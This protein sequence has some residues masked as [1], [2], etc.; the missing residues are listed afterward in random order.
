MSRKRRETYADKKARAN[1]LGYSTPYQQ[2]KARKLLGLSR[3]SKTPHRREFPDTKLDQ[4]L[5]TDIHK[6]GQES[7]AW[8]NAHS[9][10]A[11]TRYPSHG[12]DAQKRAFKAAFVDKPVKGKAGSRAKQQAIYAYLDKY[13]PRSDGK[14]WAQHYG[15]SH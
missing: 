14:S 1:R 9:R 4:L 12:S 11:I 5:R 3:S 10:Q 13:H 15:K 2:S 7:L 6:V 8:A